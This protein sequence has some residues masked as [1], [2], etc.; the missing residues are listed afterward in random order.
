MT[1]PASQAFIDNL[2]A[3]LAPEFSSLVT[4]LD[5]TIHAFLATNRLTG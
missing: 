5:E 3:N 2:L 4:T 1:G